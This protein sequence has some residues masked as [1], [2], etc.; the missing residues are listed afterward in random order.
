MNITE[1]FGEPV[2]ELNKHGDKAENAKM[3]KTSDSFF[4][5]EHHVKLH[6]G[7]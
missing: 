6:S 3:A 1:K 5:K 7:I 4:D 2:I